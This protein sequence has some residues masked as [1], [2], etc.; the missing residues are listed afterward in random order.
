VMR[1]FILAVRALP[2]DWHRVGRRRHD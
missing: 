2:P 1:R